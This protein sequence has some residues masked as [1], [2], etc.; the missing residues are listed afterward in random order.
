[1]KIHFD[2]AAD[3]VEIGAELNNQLSKAELDN[4]RLAAANDNVL[5]WP[6]IPL[7]EGWYASP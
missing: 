3:V 6:L 5:H 1:M 4:E 2:V 7:P